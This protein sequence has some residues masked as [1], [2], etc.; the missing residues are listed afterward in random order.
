VDGGDLAVADTDGFV[1]H[2]DDRREAIG[3]ARRRRHDGVTGRVIKVLVDADNDIEHRGVLNRRRD[4]DALSAAIKVALQGGGRQELAGRLQ[5]DVDADVTPRDV[6]GR[7]V[8]GEPNLVAVNV[9]RV[10]AVRRDV[11]AP[12]ALGGIKHQQMRGG[13]SAAALLVDVDDLQAIVPPGII[14]RPMGGPKGRAKGEAADAPHAIDSDS[15]VKELPTSG[16]TVIQARQVVDAVLQ[17]GAVQR[18]ER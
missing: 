16:L 14:R 5:N 9:D 4:D 8:G 6:A 12:P 1:D 15:H 11:G 10:V 7:R 13:G 18:L 3:G 2:L 17:G